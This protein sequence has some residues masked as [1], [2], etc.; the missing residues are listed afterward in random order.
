M[1]GCK[2]DFLR[3]L[4]ILILETMVRVIRSSEHSATLVCIV[5]FIAALLDG[6][7]CDVYYPFH[8]SN[9]NWSYS[10]KKIVP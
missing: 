6:I 1:F 9:S 2:L 4:K 8:L 10:K 3:V 7:Q 5:N